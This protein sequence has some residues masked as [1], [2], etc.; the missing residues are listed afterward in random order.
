MDSKL[1]GSYYTPIKLVNSMVEFIEED[2]NRTHILEPSAG[3][4]RFIEKLLKNN[5]EIDAVELINEKAEFI[6]SKFK[7]QRVNSINSDFIRY[8]FTCKKKYDYIIGNPPYINKKYLN[9]EERNLSKKLYKEF[10]LREAT[11]SNLWVSFILASIKLLKSDGTIFFVLPLEFLQVNHSKPIRIFLEKKFKAI[12]IFVFKKSIFETIQQDVCLIYISNRE[13]DI[14]NYIKYNIVK[15][16]DLKNPIGF[17]K[18][19]RN[20]PLDKWTNSIIDDEEIELIKRLSDKCKTIDTFGKITPGIVTG[21][22]NFFILTKEFVSSKRI[23]NYVVPIIPKS[24]YIGQKLIF[25]KEDFKRLNE[26][27]KLVNLLKLNDF[28]YNKL[29]KGIKEYLNEGE[30]NKINLRFKCSRRKPW[31]II[32]KSNIGNLFFFKRYGK[33]P[34]LVIN[35]SNIYTTDIAYNIILSDKYDKNSLAFCFYN[36]LTLVMCE[37]MGR[38]YAG[39]VCELT[40]NEFKKVTIPYIEINKEEIKCLDEMFRNNKDI[41]DIISYVNK[42]VLSNIATEEE[43]LKLEDIRGRYLKRRL[44]KQ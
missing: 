28:N 24:S 10:G 18:I 13:N 11:F 32:P 12:E 29:P 14:K 44:M 38:F 36:V 7:N 34:K 30:E 1:T 35:E 8:S 27:N 17:N 39:G 2:L 43:I 37:Y 31:Y 21:A 33:Y 15:D 16:V 19:M 42:K 41:N 22:N 25:N 23:K 26:D 9:E 6:R 3:D 20:M 4:G 5:C 40:P